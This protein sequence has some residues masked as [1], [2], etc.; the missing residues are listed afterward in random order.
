MIKYVAIVL[1]VT[2]NVSAMLTMHY[3]QVGGLYISSTAVVLQEM[4][5]LMISLFLLVYQRRNEKELTGA[6]IHSRLANTKDMPRIGVPGSL[7]LV[8]NNL[9]FVTTK[10]LSTAEA[11]LLMQL[12]ILATGILSYW[13]LGKILSKMQTLSLFVL[14]FGAVLAEIPKQDGRLLEEA[15]NRLLGIVAVLISVMIGAFAGI[16]TEMLLK[17]TQDSMWMRNIQLSLFGIFLGCG[18]CLFKD[19]QSIAERGF[20][21]GYSTIVW[22]VIFGNAVGGLLV[23]V[24][25]KYGDNILKSFAVA[26]SLILAYIVQKIIEPEAKDAPY[27]IP[28]AILVSVAVTLYGLFPPKQAIRSPEG[29]KQIFEQSEDEVNSLILDSDIESNSVGR[30]SSQSKCEIDDADGL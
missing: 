8:S 22:V 13:M 9:L 2:Q 19:L 27:F 18:V 16:Y 1:L 24:V 30:R 20:F 10:N 4:I 14:F 29:L 28:G 23:A 11:M 25:L 21:Q 7:Y 5:K 17:E 15:P 26:V 6:F 3:S 12:K